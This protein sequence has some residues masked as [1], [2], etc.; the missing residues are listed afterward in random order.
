VLPETVHEAVLARLDLLPG[1]E[2]EVLQV[3][4]VVG[5]TF[6]PPMLCAALPDHDPSAVVVALEELVA[7][8]VLALAGGEEDAYT[9]RHI[10]FRDVAYG[11][12]AR[13]E[14]VR[15]H[16]AVANWLEVFA[17]ERLDEFVELLA[18]HYRE[19]AQLAR[20]SAV[21]LSVEVDAGRAVRYLVRAGELASQAG[22]VGPAVAHLHAAIGLVPADEQLRLYEQLGDCAVQGIGAATG[23]QRAVAL[24]RE[25]GQPDPLTGARLLRKLL[26]VYWSWGGGAPGLAGSQEEWAAL[27]EEWA[28]LHAEA[29]RLAEEA[30]D[31]DELWRVRVAPLNAFLRPSSRA[32]LEHEREV[33]V[34]AAAYFERQ[35][36]WPALYM[37]L[38]GCA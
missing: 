35:Q 19:A 16:L 21:P 33:C 10:L 36:D 23:F 17:S 22:L 28:A 8:D 6:R 7:R 5:R 13:A 14:R 32:E 2:R 25:G 20:Q 3:A 27:W 12:L 9:F 26:T 18:Y 31:E 38:D 30:G 37:A 24:W 11:T 4:A 34:A 1:L 29:L 15:L